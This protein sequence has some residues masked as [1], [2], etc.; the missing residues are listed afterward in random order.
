MARLAR[1][2]VRCVA[3]YVMRRSYRR[4]KTFSGEDKAHKCYG[5]GRGPEGDIL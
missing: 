5:I 1:V 4:Q 2:V 3:H